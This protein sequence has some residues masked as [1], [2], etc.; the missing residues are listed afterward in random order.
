MESAKKDQD[1]FQDPSMADILQTIRNVI[2]GESFKTADNTDD[3]L[4][5]TDMV[6]ENGTVINL[7]ELYGIADAPSPTAL[8]SHQQSN[9]TKTSY[10]SA[11]NT[12]K[13]NSLISEENASASAEL[14]K[15][16][17]KTVAKPQNEGLAFRSG[18]TVEELIIELLRPQLSEWLNQNLPALVKHV[19]EKEVK[20]LIPREDD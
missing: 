12:T 13:S 15:S 2:S 18:T 20:K 9:S 5:L 11:E 4:E 8:N 17:I 3:V 7:K 16:L 10:D 1:T 6:A 14:L 19:V